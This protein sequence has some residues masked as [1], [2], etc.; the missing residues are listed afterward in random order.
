MTSKQ[1]SPNVREVYVCVANKVCTALSEYKHLGVFTTLAS[2]KRCVIK[3][4]L[5]DLK[6]FNLYDPAK[7]FKRHFSV[8]TDRWTH[9]LGVPLCTIHKFILDEYGDNLID[10]LHFNFDSH[11][12]T[13]IEEQ[14]L[15][16]LAA[17]QL[18][19][20]WK[21]NFPWE[22]SCM[23]SSILEYYQPLY[24]DIR[25][26]RHKWQDQYGVVV[27]YPEGDYDFL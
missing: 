4:V 20:T 10:V 2:A 22:L 13:I 3:Y 26:F 12:K 16:S 19:A 8:W 18:I 24:K 5:N 15:D 27:P 21:T 9:Q 6:D 23:F 7:R 14:C 25:D 11:I 1:Q 17:R